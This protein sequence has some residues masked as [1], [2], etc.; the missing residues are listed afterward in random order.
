MTGVKLVREA[1]D[2][3]MDRGLPAEEL[4]QVQ[5]I[6]E[7]HCVEGVTYHALRTR[8]AGSQRFVSVHIQVPGRWSVQEGHE[9]LE[10]I[11]QDIRQALAPVSVFTHLEPVEDPA[12]LEDEALYRTD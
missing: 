3:L 4:G 11:E 12:S 5:A 9:L 1:I 6:L 10:A 7:R 8:E 2:G